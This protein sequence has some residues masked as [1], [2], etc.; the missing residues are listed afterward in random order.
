[1]ARPQRYHAG[2]PPGSWR[3]GRSQRSI[4]FLA[5]DLP[6]DKAQKA[7]DWAIARCGR[8]PHGLSLWNMI[9]AFYGTDVTRKLIDERQQD[10]RRSA[11]ASRRTTRSLRGRW[12][13]G[14]DECD[15]GQK[16]PAKGTLK[17]RDKVSTLL[18]R[19]PRPAGALHFGGNC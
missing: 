5:A 4:P 19:R 18:H 3:V 14:K 8:L 13:R 7:R 16:G 17:P 10:L 6:E 15:A 1:M 12:T 11:E 9:S 2:L